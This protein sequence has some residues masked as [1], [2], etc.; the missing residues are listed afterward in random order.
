LFSG[1]ATRNKE[2]SDHFGKI[3]PALLDLAITHEMGHGIC[4]E[5]NERCADDYGKEL[6]EGKT[7]G[8]GT[9]QRGQPSSDKR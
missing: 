4:Q 7:P 2:L 3:G 1:A 8:C 5:E 6:R 9:A